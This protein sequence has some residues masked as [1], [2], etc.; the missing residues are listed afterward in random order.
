MIV[1]LRSFFAELERRRE[2]Q[3]PTLMD[4]SHF[5][6]ASDPIEARLAQALSRFPT[7]EL[8]Y[9]IMS[10]GLDGQNP[11]EP[12]VVADALG[13]VLP[14]VLDTGDAA[15]AR[16][17]NRMETRDLIE[18]IAG[19]E[20]PHLARHLEEI[21]ELP[22]GQKRSA[23]TDLWFYSRRPIRRLAMSTALEGGFLA[24]FTLIYHRYQSGAPIMA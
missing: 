5:W 10:Y 7:D 14:K 24:F 13:M 2:H 12:H 19:E 4:R 1:Q 20:V 22:D 3:V 8:G 15:R 11:R 6:N 21:S 18:A 16:L 23:A 9:L 17:R